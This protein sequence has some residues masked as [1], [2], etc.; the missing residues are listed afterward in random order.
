MT[1]WRLGWLVVPE[2]LTASFEKL[3][4]NL[5]ICASALAQH[6]ALAC[7][8]P[9]SMAIYKQRRAL[10]DERR[11][12]IVPA[13]QKLGFEVPAEPDGAF[14]VYL[15]CDKV[16]AKLGLTGSSALAQVLLTQARFAGF[17]NTSLSLH[18]PYSCDVP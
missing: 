4:Q 17:L 15:D 7:F 1:G 14:Y 13:M 2:A 16:C 11:R 8:E 5:F 18:I 9:E 3:A 10:F 12:Y 6:A